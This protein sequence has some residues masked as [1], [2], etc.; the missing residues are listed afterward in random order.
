AAGGL[1]GRV[2]HVLEIIGEVRQ[3]QPDELLGDGGR[4]LG[5]LVGGGV[6]DERPGDALDVHPVVLVEVLVLGGDDRVDHQWGDLFQGDVA[7]VLVVHD[8]DP[9]GAV[10]GVHVADLWSVVD[11]QLGRQLVELLQALL[12]DISGEGDTGEERGG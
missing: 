5:D 1:L 3:R 8:R 6:G 4:A 7:P 12:D 11:D 9:G 2:Y 10:R